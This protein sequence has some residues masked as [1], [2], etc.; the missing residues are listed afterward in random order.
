MHIDLE[1]RS[2]SAALDPAW[3]RA[4]A[5]RLMLLDELLDP[6]DAECIAAEMSEHEHWRAMQPG[7]AATSVMFAFADSRHQSRALDTSW[8]PAAEGPRT[9]GQQNS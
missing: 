1:L 8:L 6:L 2:E 9:P 4:C 7:V 5:R 3:V